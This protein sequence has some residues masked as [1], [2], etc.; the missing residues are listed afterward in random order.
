[1]PGIETIRRKSPLTAIT[2]AT[3]PTPANTI[4][5]APGWKRAIETAAPRVARKPAVNI[6]EQHRGTVSA[7]AMEQPH[8]FD[9]RFRRFRS[10]A[11]PVGDQQ[12]RPF[13]LQQ[14]AP[15]IAADS[16]PLLGNG[17]RADAAR[18]ILPFA[19][20]SGLQTRQHRGALTR[21]GGER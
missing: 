18:L 10:V 19:R 2:P 21:P 17:D 6:I 7:E 3:F 20:R 8:G 13:R 5:P 16:L 1:M 4:L 12:G 15:G 11:E 14:N 9:R